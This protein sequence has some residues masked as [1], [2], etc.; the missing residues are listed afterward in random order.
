VSPRV[1][2][3]LSG[4]LL[5]LLAVV[6]VGSLV[7]A[8]MALDRR[9]DR[10]LRR[11]AVEDLGRAPMILEDRSA[12]RAEALAMHALAVA[13]TKGLVDA[14]RAGRLD[15]AARL[16]R[17]AAAAYGEQPVVVSAEGDVVVGPALGP[18][19]MTTLR[20]GAHLFEYVYDAGTPRAVG[21][22]ALMSGDTLLGAAGSCSALDAALATTL[23]ALAR[24]DVTLVGRDG[25]VVASSLDDRTAARLA[26]TVLG[27]GAPPP[28]AKVVEASVAGNSLWVARGTLGD[29]A[30]VL[31][32]RSVAEELAALPGVRRGALVAGLLT[33]TLALAAG[34]FVAVVLTRPVRALAEAADRVAEGDFGA[35]VPGSRLEEL[36][37]LG[38]AFRSMRA[39]LRTR[40]DELADANAQ[41]EDRQRRLHALQAE[42]IRQDR[43]TSSARMAAE[44]AHEIRNPVANVRN[45]L[46]V[47]RRGLP[48]GSE[49]SRF[50]DMA[51]DELLRMH[52]LAEHLLDLNRPGDPSVGSCDP[53]VVATQVATLSAVGDVEARVGVVAELLDGARAPVPPDALK[54]I[55]FNLVEN[56][57]EA[58]GPTGAVEIRLR[59]EG[60]SILVDVVDDGPGIPAD[61]LGR[62]F[63]PFF[64]TKDVMHGVGLGLF[65]AEGLVRR[66]G[67]RME[68]RNRED[69]ARGALF[70][71]ALPAA[72]GPS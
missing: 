33:L 41:L 56:A 61:V 42:L 58:A 22:V 53:A 9:V 68:A 16:A 14:V 24:A 34:T 64:T 3:P 49:G 45:C 18:G 25:V 51:I 21:L 57:R 44:L 46:E 69:G 40:L 29:A 7:P 4:A 11:V 60:D 52:E 65:V 62:I 48:D 17:D 35:P 23:S 36:D 39:A 71:V 19:S 5:L 43:L 8:G 12:Q 67:G 70:R 10:E 66:Y 28:A 55:L 32:T 27:G 2:F 54:Q 15:R 50:A 13:S 20:R 59:A 38:A 47:V 72:P 37:R 6:L 1:R 26:A 31:F 63:D 30:T